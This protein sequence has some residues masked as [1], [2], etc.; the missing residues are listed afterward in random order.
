MNPLKRAGVSA[1]VVQWLRAV[2]GSAGC[3]CLFIIHPFFI[4]DD[5]KKKKEYKPSKKVETYQLL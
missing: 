1:Q 4:G 3:E 2:P 5:V